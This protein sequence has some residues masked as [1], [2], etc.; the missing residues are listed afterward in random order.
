MATTMTGG[1][2]EAWQR[3][4]RIHWVEE[5]LRQW[6]TRKTKLVPMVKPISMSPGRDPRACAAVGISRC[7]KRVFSILNFGLSSGAAGALGLVDKSSIS[8][9]EATIGSIFKMRK[10]P[11][12][13][14]EASL[15]AGPGSGAWFRSSGHA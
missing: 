1:C 2:E 12:K 4:I 3:C 15:I 14:L 10:M 9:L 7:A 6:G 5:C 13:H 8:F 11:R